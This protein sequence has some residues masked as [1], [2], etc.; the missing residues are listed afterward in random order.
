[1]RRASKVHHIIKPGELREMEKE[2]LQ[3]AKEF[4]LDPFTTIFEL[5]DFDEMNEVVSYSGFPSR[6]PHWRFGMEYETMRKSYAYGLHKIYELVINNDPCYAYLLQSNSQIEQKIVIAHVYG[7]SD[8]FK[9]NLWY[10]PTNRKM[11]DQMANHGA[12]IKKYMDK[13]GVDAVEDFADTVLSI[14]HMIDY[15]SMY[16]PHPLP[17]P[18]YEEEPE[19]DNAVRKIPSAKGY[20]DRFI[21]PPEFIE[22]QKRKI[23]EE[24]A[25]K[26]KFPERPQRDV[27]LFLIEHAPLDN[28][29]K[30]VMCMIR[31]ESYYFAPQAMT[32]IMNEGWACVKENT[33]AYTDHGLMTMGEVVAGAAR[34]VHDGKERRAIY[35]RN[36]VRDREMVC[37][38][39][40]RGLML[41][42]STNHRV[43]LAGGPEWRPLSRLSV[44]DR[45]VIAGGMNLWPQAEV[46]I[47]WKLGRRVS[48]AEACAMA[49]PC[50]KTYYR[51]RTGKLI[52]NL[53]SVSEAQAIDESPENR[54]LTSMVNGRRSVRIPETMGADLSELCGYL[55]GDGH[56]SR[57]K[58]HLGLT[59]GDLEK[60]ERFRELGETLFGVSCVV[61]KD[62]GRWRALLHSETASDFFVQ[63]LG[64]KTGPC[65]REKEIPAVIL[66]S[67]E[68][69]VRAFLRAYFDCDGYAGKQGVILST[70]SDK[71]AEQVQLLL[72][73]YGILSRRRKQTDGCWHLDIFGKSAVTFM[74]RIGFGLQRKQDALLDYLKGHKHFKEEAWEDEIVEIS[75]ERG[76]VYDISVEE[77]HRYAAG[78]FIN[79]NSY[80]HSK[81]L[82]EKCLADEE[83][84]DYADI[85]AGVLGGGA[86]MNPYKLG[87]E[88][89]RDIEDR[90]NKGKFGREY[91]ECDDYRKKERWDT[92]LNKGREKIFEV[93]RVHNDITFLDNFLTEEFCERHKLFLYRYNPQRG[94]YE[95]ASRDFN[96]IKRSMLF[97]MT[98]MGHPIIEVEDGNYKN[99]AELQLRHLHEGIDL[100]IEEGKDTL[101]SLYKLWKRPVNLV[102]IVE[103]QQKLLTFDGTEHKEQ[104]LSEKV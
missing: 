27:L 17:R 43:L 95:I 83:V 18:Q 68:P 55:V 102:T 58:R 9:N 64:M 85:N 11:L 45:V 15:H 88:L 52:R 81:I 32:K 87:V 36:I 34:E 53:D 67:P 96:M 91:D 19:V 8:F 35:D 42:G 94:V 71:L 39:T 100:E 47:S 16:S 50:E 77:T 61:K 38:R 25:R 22:E 99:R 2:M 89:Y 44:G 62:G 31:E 76:D 3:N 21:N 1:M 23:E 97:K 69:V 82:T 12:R 28:W 57:I 90:W 73:N 79:H 101:R 37:V 72:L 78:G 40:R 59:S 24:R 30:D 4:G 14:E 63:A 20:M 5:I 46:A 56:I 98:N 51:Y 84:V 66:R 29:Q 48:I 74:M 104:V 93:R 13:Y 92:Q 26:R 103:G 49:G 41:T 6:Y 70:T 60:V 80:W 33:L 75:H 10:A 65:A 86:A 54:S 7:H